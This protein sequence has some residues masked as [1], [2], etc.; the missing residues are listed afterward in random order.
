MR[1]R[2]QGFRHGGS[3]GAAHHDDR[4]C[5]VIDLAV[6]HRFREIVRLAGRTQITAQLDVH[7]ESLAEISFRRQRSVVAEELHPFKHD[8]VLAHKLLL[9]CSNS[10]GALTPEKGH[11]LLIDAFA[12]LGQK[13]SNCRLLLA[14][15]GRLR[16]ELERQAQEAGLGS[17]I[18]FAGFVAEVES[19]YAAGDLFVFPSLSEGAGSSLIQAMAYGLPVLALARGGMAEI[20]EDGRTGIL[21]QETNAEALAS[22]AVRMLQDSEFRERSARAARET[23]ASRYSAERM[24]DGTARIFGE[25]I[26]GKGRSR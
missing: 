15:E 26:A 20:I 1:R 8:S 9:F 7:Q 23:A 19:V 18:V 4:S 11:A 5:A 25:L 16:A 22:A 17:A 6:V 13:I 21:V 10:V 2:E 24:V 3:V 12:K 14:G